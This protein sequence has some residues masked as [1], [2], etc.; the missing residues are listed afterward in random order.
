M[1]EKARYRPVPR[2]IYLAIKSPTVVLIVA[3]T[4]P[5]VWL[6][7][8]RNEMHLAGA[9]IDGLVVADPQHR[10]PV[11]VDGHV[12]G[13][14]PSHVAIREIEYSKSHVSAPSF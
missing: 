9:R 7:P 11:S 2:F 6:A 14:L 8:V 5:A 12:V 4:V 3:P 13:D 10:I 1:K